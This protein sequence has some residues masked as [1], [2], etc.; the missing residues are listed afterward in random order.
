MDFYNSRVDF[1]KEKLQFCNLEVISDLI[2]R[3]KINTE[4]LEILRQSVINFYKSSINYEL[5]N[6][7][8]NGML[9]PKIENEIE[10]ESVLVSFYNVLKKHILLSNYNKI[11]YPVV[12]Y[13]TGKDNNTRDTK[14][15]YAHCDAWAGWSSNSTLLYLPLS[16]DLK[17]NNIR[18]FDIPKNINQSWLL[19][20]NF[21]V[22]QHEEVQHCNMLEHLPEY[23]Y[24]YIM[25]ISVVHQTIRLKNSND[26]L[27]IDI[28]IFLKFKDNNVGYGSESTLDESIF[29]EI[30][31]TVKFKAEYK[32]GEFD[33]IT[34]LKRPTYY[35]KI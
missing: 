14:S 25:D 13:K 8:P 22:A 27:S 21:K 29:K 12:R 5:V 20:K 9:V 23:G 32:M 31:R 35:K 19:P 24:L 18:M 26:R 17:N 10:Y 28:P 30:G 15:E 4:G 1:L 2:Y 16:G 3:I 11:V 33:G 34:G 6:M 7:T